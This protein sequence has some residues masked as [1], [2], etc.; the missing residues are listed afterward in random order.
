MHNFKVDE[1][2]AVDAFQEF[3]AYEPL[4]WVPNEVNLIRSKFGRG[5]VQYTTI[6]S[7]TLGEPD[8][9]TSDGKEDQIYARPKLP[10]LLD[11][12][13][14]TEPPDEVARPS[15]PQQAEEAVTTDDEAESSQESDASESERTA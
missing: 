15:V 11:Y 14:Y 1:D 9:T 8:G 6:E 12:L 3:G 5:G 10:T 4:F 7:F 13:D 2:E